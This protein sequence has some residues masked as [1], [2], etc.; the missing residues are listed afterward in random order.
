MTMNFLASENKVL[1]SCQVIFGSSSYSNESLKGAH[2]AA[3]L[4]L[5]AP[6]AS[7]LNSSMI[8]VDIEDHVGRTPL[9]WAVAYGHEEISNL[10]LQHGADPDHKNRYGCTPLFYAAV[11][12]NVRIVQ[13]LIKAGARVDTL[14]QNGRTP[15]FHAASGNSLHLMPVAFHG[16]CL[17][18]VKLLLDHGG[19]AIQVDKIGQTPLFAAAGNGRESVVKLLIERNAHIEYATSSDLGKLD[20]LAFAAMNGH[21]GITKLLYEIG[22]HSVSGLDGVDATSYVTLSNLLK[23][24]PEGRDDA[25]REFKDKRAD[26]NIR[27]S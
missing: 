6:L 10:L 27:D 16:D 14:D 9:S 23:A 12:G 8:T 26:P 17:A 5:L 11:S 4:G 13:S 7:M 1:A 18:S 20:P 3:F 15:L 25:F 2:L 19:S 22:A 24:G 21:S